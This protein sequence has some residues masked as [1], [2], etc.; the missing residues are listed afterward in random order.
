[1]SQV[2]VRPIEI[3][4]FLSYQLIL[5]RVDWHTARCE[6]VFYKEVAGTFGTSQRALGGREL[7]AIQGECEKHCWP[8][9]NALVV[10]KKK[11]L[12][13]EAYQPFHHPVTKSEFEQIKQEICDFDWTDKHL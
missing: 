13:G 11:R 12:P 6:K 4:D 10:T 2:L 1:M 5:I 9:L 7:T 3:I 8:H